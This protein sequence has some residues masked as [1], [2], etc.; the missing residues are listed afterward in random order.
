MASGKIDVGIMDGG[1]YLDHEAIKDSY[2]TGIVFKGQDRKPAVVKPLPTSA[3]D[4]RSWN[5]ESEKYE[6]FDPEFYETL[7]AENKA[8]YEYYFGHGTAVA[9]IIV[10]CNPTANILSLKMPFDFMVEADDVQ[11]SRVP[12]AEMKSYADQEVAKRLKLFERMKRFIISHNIPIVNCS[13][14][15]T[16]ADKQRE[17]KSYYPFLEGDEL[18]EV[19]SLHFRGI[20]NVLKD[21]FGSREF[22]DHTLFVVAAGNQRVD[23]DTTEI[24]PAILQQDN[25]LTVGGTMGRAE[26]WADREDFGSNYSPQYVAV[27]TLAK[28]FRVAWGRDI[29]KVKSGTSLATPII[30][31]LCCRLLQQSP[32]LSPRQ[33]KDAALSHGVRVPAIA[34][35]VKDG[36]YFNPFPLFTGLEPLIVET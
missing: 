9:N 21:F 17:I 14:T 7:S 23:L 31:A 33:I 27:A 24:Y 20:A 16:F 36:L 18:V 26:W 6:Q 4:H 10:A 30:T 11:K 29:F 35:R 1:V 28:A 25:L 19:T 12:F 34:D 13:W 5:F 2:R 22:R 3:V 32:G 8:N 15:E